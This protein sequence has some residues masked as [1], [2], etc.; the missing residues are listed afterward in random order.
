[1]R[2]HERCTK[3]TRLLLLH[4]IQDTT[5][6]IRVSPY[7][8]YMYLLCVSMECVFMSIGMYKLWDIFIPMIVAKT[9]SPPQNKVHKKLH[10]TEKHVL[11]SV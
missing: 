4:M 7:M 1:M 3:H 9:S 6:E 5:Q 8:V 11:I 2:N 10:N